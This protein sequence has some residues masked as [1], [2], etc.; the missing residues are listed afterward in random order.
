MCTLFG[1]TR[2]DTHQLG[3]SWGR[4]V[5]Q[6]RLAGDGTL[7]PPQWMEVVRQGEV[8]SNPANEFHNSNV[9]PPL[10]IPAVWFTSFKGITHSWLIEGWGY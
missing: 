4:I 3:I 7:Y 2:G 10:T 6:G 9:F 5:D 8:D 1:T